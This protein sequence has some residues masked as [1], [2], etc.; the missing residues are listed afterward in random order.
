MRDYLEF[1]LGASRYSIDDI[2]DLA[3][4]ETNSDRLIRQTLSVPGWEDPAMRKAFVMAM[5]DILRDEVLPCPVSVSNVMETS[6]STIR[7]W[8]KYREN[9][10]RGK[11]VPRNG[12]D[13]IIFNQP[14]SPEIINV[15]DQNL[16]ALPSNQKIKEH[17]KLVA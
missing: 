13:L 3:H 2:L 5:L 7:K 14:F 6:E 11:L 16:D 15:I 12:R 17:S 1:L 4:R 9:N 8:L 10:G